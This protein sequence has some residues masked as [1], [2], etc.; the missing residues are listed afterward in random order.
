MIYMDG[1]GGDDSDSPSKTIASEK[2][3]CAVCAG[4]Q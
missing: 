3:V 1:R 2:Y 4:G